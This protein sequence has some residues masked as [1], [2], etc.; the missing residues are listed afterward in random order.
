MSH[1]C[2]AEIELVN[3]ETHPL[4]Q[5]VSAFI[6]CSSTRSIGL[7]EKDFGVRSIPNNLILNSKYTLRYVSGSFKRLSWYFTVHL[8]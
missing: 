2:R 6:V 8:A 5:A 7:L 3:A 4:W 1:L